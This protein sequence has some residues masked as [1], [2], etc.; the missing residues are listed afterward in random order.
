MTAAP[1]TVG[2]DDLAIKALRMMEDGG[3]RHLPVVMGRRVLGIVS[4]SD[5]PG[6]EKVELEVERHYWEAVG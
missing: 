3:Y 5:F 1:D 6:D 2:P 4:R